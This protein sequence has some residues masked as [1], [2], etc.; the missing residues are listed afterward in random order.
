MKKQEWNN[1][2]KEYTIKFVL[3]TSIRFGDDLKCRVIISLKFTVQ[4]VGRLLYDIFC[5]YQKFILFCV[6]SYFKRLIEV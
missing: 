2:I 6:L 5:Y 3:C 1:I 4:I